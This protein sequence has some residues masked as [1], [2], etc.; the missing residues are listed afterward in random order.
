MQ[1]YYRK[2]WL[3][4]INI[5]LLERAQIFPCQILNNFEPNLNDPTKSKVGGSTKR[6]LFSS[7]TIK[8]KTAGTTLSGLILS[9]KLFRFIMRLFTQLSRNVG[10]ILRALPETSQNSQFRH[11]GC[12]IIRYRIRYIL[13]FWWIENFFPFRQIFTHVISQII[14]LMNST[15]S[16]TF[17]ISQ[18]TKFEPT[19]F[20][21]PIR[22]WVR[23]GVLS[24]FFH[25]LWIE[26]L[27]GI[28]IAVLI[29]RGLILPVSCTFQ[30]LKAISC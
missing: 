2:F 21:Q 9:L 16:W 3:V 8:F 26:I 13:R 11:G 30:M 7:S 12:L 4:Y 29:N 24:G 25:K 6:R 23:L 20:W 18:T 22:R 14:Q 28:T 15:V 10:F 19:F 27:K 17:K 1:A 5:P